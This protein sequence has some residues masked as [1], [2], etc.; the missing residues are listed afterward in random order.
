MIFNQTADL[1]LMGVK[2][3]TRRPAKPHDRITIYKASKNRWVK[4]LFNNQMNR[5]RYQVGKTYA[6]QVGRGRKG[7]GRILV[8][9]L[10]LEHL[11]AISH[12]DAIAEGFMSVDEFK[13]TW[14]RLYPRALITNPKVVV[15]EFELVKV[16]R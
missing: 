3:Q 8:T 5:S 2:T 12:A 6:V 15:I 13:E 10:R 16:G 1:V 4:C 9:N 11:E 14:D 7:I